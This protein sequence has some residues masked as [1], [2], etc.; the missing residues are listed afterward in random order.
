MPKVPLQTIGGQRVQERALPVVPV[1]QRIP[2]GG[3][4]EGVEA[5]AQETRR[6]AAN[7][8]AEGDRQ[9]GRANNLWVLGA[10]S[11]M[12]EKQL[13][14][15]SNARKRNGRDAFNLHDETE[16]EFDDFA[17]ELEDEANNEDQKLALQGIKTSRGTS[18]NRTITGH[19]NNQI[20]VVETQE[21]DAY[22]FNLQNS[23]AA[24][25]E[26]PVRIAEDFL[27]FNAAVD[28]EVERQGLDP[29]A[30]KA[31]K[32]GETTKFHVGVINQMLAN[33]DNVS[34]KQYFKD[35]ADEMTA[36]SRRRLTPSMDE[37]GLR[38][39][40]QA[41]TDRIMN[42]KTGVSITDDEITW[43]QRFEEA[44][45]IKE[46][47]LR[48]EVTRRLDTEFARQNRL[49]RAADNDNYMSA[50]NQVEDTK[51]THPKDTIGADRWGRMTE[52]QRNSLIR[53][54]DFGAETMDFELYREYYSLPPEQ[55]AAMNHSELTVKYLSKFDPSYRKS[56]EALWLRDSDA[57]ATG[58]HI[59]GQ[60][61]PQEFGDRFL[62]DIG[63][64]PESGR[65]F[66]GNNDEGE[67]KYRL[68]LE[69]FERRVIAF[70]K[71]NG[72]VP[73]EAESKQIASDM[74][75]ETVRIRDGD[76]AETMKFGE[77]VL[78]TGTFGVTPEQISKGGIPFQRIKDGKLRKGLVASDVLVIEN[79]L[80]SFNVS[81]P[82]VVDSL[83]SNLV[84]QYA[85]AIRD[86][87]IFKSKQLVREY[88]KELERRK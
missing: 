22:R 60:A 77:A 9:L 82:E 46:P 51:G 50:L 34:A 76:D 37:A 1:S 21:S 88:K 86:K 40:A 54:S 26:D 13:E 87:D 49:E 75:E 41:E 67:A 3:A 84:Q 25:Y 15:E 52:A 48:D 4:G 8:E 17:K 44:K 53:I 36:E 30:R 58:S 81:K 72:K 28:D 14:I 19:V 18:L 57:V 85:K 78:E 32:L 12:A 61:T 73:G 42:L 80:R 68:F 47:K 56:A 83:Y 29:E 24:H 64:L 69:G 35:N 33:E 70:Q 27:K 6:V 2:P 74:W 55:K 65:D 31:F 20:E 43:T 11:R 66:P 71:E 59:K 79:T 62:K 38:A 16:K 10:E 63:F 23:A 7:I 45:K 39:D 5:V